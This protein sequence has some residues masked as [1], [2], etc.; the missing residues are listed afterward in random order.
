MSGGDCHYEVKVPS[1]TI[2]TYH[3]GQG[4]REHGGTVTSI[5][6][7]FAF[8]STEEKYRVLILGAK[9]RGRKGDMP[10]DH[11]TGRGWVKEVKGHYHD[12]IFNKHAR[13]VPFIVEAYGGVV[14]HA[15]AHMR[16]LAERTQGR[17]AIDRTR[18][19]S[20]RVSTRSFYAYHLQQISKAAVMYDARAIRKEVLALKQK[21]F[22]AAHA[23]PAGSDPA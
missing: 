21:A 3:A 2:A 6:N 23:A 18:Y 17:N 9:G 5:G 14:P 8:G 22:K 7:L 16:R 20:L 1:P 11:A 19:G 13:V 12:A 10:F 4:S 15:R